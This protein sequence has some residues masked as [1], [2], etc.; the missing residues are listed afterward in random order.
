VGEAAGPII[1]SIRRVD[2]EGLHADRPLELRLGRPDDLQACAE[3][4]DAGISD[5]QRRLNQPLLGGDLGPVRRLLAH[6]LETDPERFWVA[7]RRHPGGERVVG[8]GSAT[9]RGDVWFLAMLFVLPEEQASGIGRALLA[10]TSPGGVEP[11]STGLAH[12]GPTVLGTVTDSAQP[13]S[14]AMYAR[15][16]IV[17]RLPIFHLVGRPERPDALAIL[18]QAVVP[19]PFDEI[20]AGPPD[21]PGHRLLVEAIGEIDE[22]LLGYEHA[23]D[24]RF[25]R[26]EGM[27]GFLYR[28]PDGRPI[29]YGY[30]SAVGRIGPVAALEEH[31]LAPIVGHL[32]TSLE[33]RGASS[34][35]I[36]GAAG[37]TFRTLLRAGLRIEG[38]PALLCWSRPFASFERY[39]PLSLALV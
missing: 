28:G 18:P 24:H 26:R 1:P 16:G 15:S 19:I 25:A 10:R 11:D 12:P 37:E 17:P 22:A 36:P 31:L 38:F 21:G 8:F 4:W 5:Y 35:W 14:N 9:I 32:L 34:V 27:V 3:T 23:V 6:L 39:V 20:A 13:I 33:P 30:T 7:T 2:A 29:G